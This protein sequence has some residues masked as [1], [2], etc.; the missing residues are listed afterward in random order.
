MT[1][2]L[3]FGGRDMRDCWVMLSGTGRIVKVR[4]PEPGLK[5]AFTA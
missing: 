3:A 4:W 5:P 1:C 2:N